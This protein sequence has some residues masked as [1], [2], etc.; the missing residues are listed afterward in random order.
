MLQN[1]LIIGSITWDGRVGDV[2]WAL[3]KGKGARRTTAG[4]GRVAVPWS[5]CM[6]QLHIAVVQ[7]VCV[8]EH[9]AFWETFVEQQWSSLQLGV[10]E[11]APFFLLLKSAVCCPPDVS[12][13][14]KVV[15]SQ[16]SSAAANSTASLENYNSQNTLHSR[17]QWPPRCL[18]LLYML[19]HGEW[20]ERSAPGALLAYSTSV[21][22]GYRCQAFAFISGLKDDDGGSRVLCQP[23]E[24]FVH[25]WLRRPITTCPGI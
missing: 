7:A 18:L 17:T 19:L 12:F 10:G 21:L 1:G 5:A 6:S 2:P 8:T 22:N 9:K 16:L 20:W 24:G 11:L 3:F 14:S 23:D 13:G 15:G 25:Y 4:A